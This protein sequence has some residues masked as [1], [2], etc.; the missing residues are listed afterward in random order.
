M[1]DRTDEEIFL[2]IKAGTN[3]N[4]K[5]AELKSQNKLSRILHVLQNTEINFS[6]VKLQD[7][8]VFY[9]LKIMKYL[10]EP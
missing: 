6:A 3:L 2:S 9:E 8:V 10:F 1:T 5:K 7:K 4:F